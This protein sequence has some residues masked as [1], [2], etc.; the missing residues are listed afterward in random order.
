MPQNAHSCCTQS[1]LSPLTYVNTY[2]RRHVNMFNCTQYTHMCNIYVCGMHIG[3][4]SASLLLLALAFA[5]V[6]MN[7]CAY[8][9]FFCVCF[10]SVIFFTNIQTHSAIY[11]C[12]YTEVCVRA[13]V[14]VHKRDLQCFVCMYVLLS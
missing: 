6:I 11:S 12:V 8:L 2:L 7:C 13:H 10:T 5:T 9:R 1:M 14:C 4:S 3:F